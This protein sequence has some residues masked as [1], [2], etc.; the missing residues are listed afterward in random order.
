M[1]RKWLHA[2]ALAT[3]AFVGMAVWPDLAA[4]ERTKP[5]IGKVAEHKPAAA[6]VAQHAP[7]SQA[8]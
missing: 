7:V 6:P 5:V 2:A 8:A 1:F 4:D 3:G